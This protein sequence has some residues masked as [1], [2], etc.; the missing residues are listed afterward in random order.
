MFLP[1]EYYHHH[2][3]N[4]DFIVTILRRI[5][6]KAL[7]MLQ[8]CSYNCYSH[9][10]SFIRCREKKCRGV[11]NAM[12]IGMES[13]I[14]VPS[15]NFDRVLKKKKHES[16]LFQ[17]FFKKYSKKDLSCAV[18]IRGEKKKKKEQQTLNS[19]INLYR[20]DVRQSFVPP[21]IMLLHGL[22]NSLSWSW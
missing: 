4:Y 20:I 16:I 18:A 22:Q 7:L 2:G 19:K 6:S 12:S 13:R 14:G 21:L 3:W 15:S 5:I 17:V 8:E 9:N 11:R 1:P 10:L